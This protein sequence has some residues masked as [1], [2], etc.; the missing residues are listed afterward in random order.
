MLHFQTNLL[1]QMDINYLI[2]MRQKI[3]ITEFLRNRIM[4]E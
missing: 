1:D 4:R 2:N 3:E